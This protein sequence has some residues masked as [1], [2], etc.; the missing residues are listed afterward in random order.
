VPLLTGLA[1]IEWKLL[2]Q[3]GLRSLDFSLSILQYL[4]LC[5][6]LALN[7]ASQLKNDIAKAGYISSLLHLITLIIWQWLK[8]GPTYSTRQS[9][10][11]AL[12]IALKPLLLIA[13]ED[14]LVPLALAVVH[15]VALSRLQLKSVPL[16]AML[17]YLSGQCYFYRTS[18]RERFSSIQFGKA[19]LGFTEYRFYLHGALVLMNTYSAHIISC[20]MVPIVVTSRYTK[21]V[22]QSPGH[23]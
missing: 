1:L 7:D 6:V 14:S 17:M 15:F 8:L 3:A 9:Y 11:L 18:H 16:L 19:F 13:G 12:S 21:R 5:S 22:A 4:L 23:K 10:I 2:K 20:L